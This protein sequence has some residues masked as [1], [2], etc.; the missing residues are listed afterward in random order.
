[1]S[2]G[3]A[4]QVTVA[5]LFSQNI[6]RVYVNPNADQKQL[7]HVTRTIGIAVALLALVG[8]IV[9]RHSLVKTILDYFN[10]LS[11]VMHLGPQRLNIV[12]GR[13]HHS[14]ITCHRTLNCCW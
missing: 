1:M 6:Y 4:V 2:S 7:V 9:M 3:D 14:T 10:I 13:H 11:L 5:G 12:P 8:A